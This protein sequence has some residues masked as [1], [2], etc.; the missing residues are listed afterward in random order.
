MQTDE[1]HHAKAASAAQMRADDARRRA[2]AA[3][4]AAERASTEY[5]R[6]VQQRVADIHSELA[7]SHDDYART[8]R[9]G[10]DRAG[11]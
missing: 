7:L 2:V 5:A 9:R 10:A 8:L 4:Q 11:P 1:N 3:R 6:R